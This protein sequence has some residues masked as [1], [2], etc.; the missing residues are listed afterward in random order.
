MRKAWFA[1]TALT[2]ALLMSGCVVVV[3]DD[4]H[5]DGKMMHQG[6]SSDGYRVLDTDGDYTRLAGD[7]NLRGRVGGDV[8]L[9]AGDVDMDG[10]EIG[11]E[12]SIAA[13]DVTFR[14]SVDGEASVAGGDV[15]WNGD[16]G[17]DL[18][19][20]AGDLRA[21]GR[22]EGRASLA[23]GELDIR[24]WYGGGLNAQG[25]EIELS[26]EVDGP[27]KLISAEHLRRSDRDEGHIEI[28]GTLHQGGEICARTL[29]IADGARISG[30]LHVYTEEEPDVASGA[31]VERIDY[32]PRD[33]RD[34]DDLVEDWD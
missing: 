24:G 13:G 34:C 6:R 23:A 19:I 14:G 10:M 33:G 32:Q 29:E 26:G 30:L 21:D 3:A 11:G 7:L 18:S 20:A 1:A 27:L 2:G 16:V 5:D 25:G 8:S 31:R 9:V 12:L 22:I 4:D 28:T 17:R 15:N